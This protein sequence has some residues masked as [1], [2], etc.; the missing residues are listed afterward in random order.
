MEQNGNS[1]VMLSMMTLVGQKH[2]QQKQP[3]I[4]VD[5]TKVKSVSKT[6]ATLQVVSNPILNAENSPIAKKIFHNLRDLNADLVRYVPWY[7]Y[8]HVAV[9]ELDPPNMS[10]RATSWNFTLLKQQFYDTFEAVAYNPGKRQRVVINFSTQPTWMFNTSDWSYNDDPNLADWNYP[11][12][13]W[14]PQTTALVATYY[15]RLASWIIHGSFTDEFGT[16]VTG[17]PAYGDAV[18]HWEIFNEPDGEHS[19]TWPIYNQMYDAIVAEI[20]RVAGPDHS[21]T[22]LGMALK[23]HN[24]WDWWKGFLTLDHHTPEGAQAVQNGYASFHWYASV[25]YRPNIQAYGQAFHQIPTILKEVDQIIA[26]RDELSPTTKLALNEAGVIPP[27][28]NEKDAVPVPPIFYNAAAGVFT[29]L[30]AEVSARGVD[31][32]GSSQLCGCPAIPEWNIP[33]RQYPGVSMTNWTTG[34]GNPRYWALKMILNTFGPGDKIIESTYYDHHDNDLFVQARLTAKDRKHS[35][36]IVNKSFLTK[37]V[38]LPQDLLSLVHSFPVKV[39]VVDSTTHDRPWKEFHLDPAA[40]SLVLL[41]F[42]VAVVVV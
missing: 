21:I 23:G 34:D 10:T 8:P 13:N 22:F 41:P 2:F 27:S 9:A 20:S 12:G 29:V 18:T 38:V 11:K 37:I 40:R 24:E 19:L 26:L 14:V 6:T 39:M 35:L 33:D 5:W 42:A 31:L 16:K 36:I 30:W 32:V 17:G 15:G 25:P 7:P 4:H 1:N 3:T 28:D